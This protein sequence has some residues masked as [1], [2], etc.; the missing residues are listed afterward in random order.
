MCGGGVGIQGVF[1]NG[2][3]SFVLGGAIDGLWD[4]VEVI[5]LEMR[6]FKVLTGQWVE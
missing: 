2:G 5:W 1:W 4:E 3:G 6:V